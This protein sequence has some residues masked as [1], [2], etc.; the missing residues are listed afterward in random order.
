[1]ANQAEHAQA[2]I[3]V[4][5]DDE[6]NLSLMR[7]VLS[8]AGYLRIETVSDSSTVIARVLADPP[9]LVLLDLHMPDPDGFTLLTELAAAVPH[10]DIVPILVLTSDVTV[11][12]RERALRHGA[13]DFLTK[14]FHLPE[15]LLRVQNLLRVRAIHIRVQAH[16]A[17]VT[18]EL[19]AHAS[20]ERAHEDQRR[21]I[22]D[23]VERVLDGHGL[24]MVFQPVVDLIDGTIA[25]AEALAR[26]TAE[27]AP[28]PDVWFLEADE[29]GRRVDAE[30]YAVGRALDRLDE[31]PD[32]AF[33]SV[34]ACA[35]TIRSGALAASLA[36]A[37]GYRL[38]V[39]LTEHESIEDY[40]GLIAGID[41]LR[42]RGIRL[43]VD[44]TGSGF[45]GLKHILRLS[46]DIIKLDGALVTG[47]DGD[48]ARRSLMAAMVHFASET[49]TMLIGEGI[50][51]D[52]ELSVLRSL[53][54]SHGQGY[55]L[56]RPGPLP[57][58]AIDVPRLRTPPP[59]TS[60]PIGR[61]DRSLGDILHDGPV[62]E[63]S[64]ACLRLQLLEARVD[65]GPMHAELAVVIGGIRRSV[66]QLSEIGARLNGS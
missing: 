56:A 8:L 27:G 59:P 15:L 29:V 65:D 4:V 3:V 45:S 47:V 16:D 43:A 17:G 23:R 55:L 46:P 21:V 60:T 34:N 6:S 62:Q 10:D 52:D 39:E 58:A 11:H 9:A 33:L 20:V 19:A 35:E 40:P 61:W 18:R 2:R 50:E 66:A 48:P 38:V 22:A 32:D 44:D 57:L 36:D 7:H 30:V 28:P 1:M 12:T 13:H 31:L 53:G 5:D 25:G 37:P 51:T 26:F 24:T 42:E 64:A 49:G 14:P 63:L 41:V 54:L